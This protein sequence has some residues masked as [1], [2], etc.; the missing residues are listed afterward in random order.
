[1]LNETASKAVHKEE[2]CDD[3]GKSDIMNAVNPVKGI[4]ILGLFRRQV[5]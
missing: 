2:G 1:M 4:R 3:R 5:T